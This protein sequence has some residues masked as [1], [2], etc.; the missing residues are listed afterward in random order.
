MPNVIE[1]MELGAICYDVL[2]R[3]IIKILTDMFAE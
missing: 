2:N 3:Q 1:M